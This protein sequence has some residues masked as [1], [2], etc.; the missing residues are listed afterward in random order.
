MNP[1]VKLALDFGPLAVFFT[2][3]KLSDIFF[4]TGALMVATTISIAVTYSLTKTVPIMPLITGVLVLIFGGLTLWLNSEFFIKI[5]LTI[6][7]VL[8]GSGLLVGLAMG[9]PLAKDMMGAAVELPD[10]VWRTITW[11]LIALFFL[12]AA[13]NEVARN[14][15]STAD[16]V[17]F[18]VWGVTGLF[19]LFAGLNS[20]LIAKHQIEPKPA[21]AVPQTATTTATMTASPKTTSSNLQ[22]QA[23]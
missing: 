2:V 18:K 19:F 17:T 7:E 4:A 5:K 20:P 13:L 9:R 12:I 14:T 6:I 3:F 15:L 21:G 16:W 1:F 10:P 22:D 8:L 23:S 11:R